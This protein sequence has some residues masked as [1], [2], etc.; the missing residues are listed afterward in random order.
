M[1]AIFDATRQY[2]YALW[3]VWDVAAPRVGFVLLN[4]SQADETVN[5]PTIRRCM[6]FARSWGYGSVEIVNLFAY[7]TPYPKDLRQV[8]DPVGQDN[9]RILQ[10][11]A[12]RVDRVIVAWG[13]W[14]N[15]QRRDQIVLNLFPAIDLFCFGM[16]Q[17][18]QP[19]HPL[20]LRRDRQPILLREVQARRAECLP[21]VAGEYGDQTAR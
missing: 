16:T 19:V 12:H 1:T 10:T 8:P 5:D 15:F 2:R 20:Y 7:R 13:N 18:G 11:L 14:G 21:A 4:P 9:D 3:R 6:N 17:Q